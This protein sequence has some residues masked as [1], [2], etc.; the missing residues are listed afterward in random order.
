MPDVLPGMTETPLKTSGL[1]A[2]RYWMH[3]VL[4]VDR[5]VGFTVL[6]RAWASSAGLVTVA[7]IARF[8]SPAQQ[9]YY[10]T[11][12]SLVALQIV[13]ELGFSFVILQ[14]ASHE[15]SCLHISGDY[16]I[17]GDPI[18]HA[19]LASV[20]QKAVRWYSAGAVL[21]AVTLV[22]SGFYF[23]A[24]HQHGDTVSWHLA[25]YLD[26]VMAALNFQ[27]DP[28]L[29]FLEGCGYV[30]AVARLRFMQSV[31][32][33]LLAW[34]A[35]ATGHGLFAPSMMLFGMASCSLLWLY[36][37]R[38]LLLGLLRHDTGNNRIRWGE[39][40]WPFQWRIAVSWASG[41][42]LFS[43]F[44]PVLFA[45]RGA[46]EAG[47]MGM[48]LSLVNAI[49][50]IA[51]SWVSTKSA[52]FGAL[53]AGKKYHEL[54][55]IFS[56]AL[57]QSFAVAIAGALIAWLGCVYINLQHLRFAQRLLPPTSLGILMICMVVN[58]IIFAQAYY[59]RAH[60][61]EVFFLNSLIG[62]LAV[63]LSTFVVGRHY[64]AAGIVL[65]C[66]IVNFG[67]LIWA[68]YKFRK[69]RTLWHAA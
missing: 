23:F 22:P 30:A 60:K 26:A 17:T 4:G 67:G 37:K 39:E 1:A 6:A 57:R 3:R 36:R 38:R 7:L 53:I 46:I 28:L 55:R 16:E 42:F 27:L 51:V 54:D 66:C 50:A 14:L 31:A 49:Q 45:Y 58:I 35:L 64:G 43:L 10:Y 48:S 59:L 40:V 2:I 29:S 8:L 56:T 25:W 11:F 65:S 41:Y 32:G 21:V 12:G 18:A 24:T 69:Y 20:L 44:N 61:Q 5:A 13:F 34:G 52:P 63:A 68:T 9:G 15:R 19:R 62:A 47:Q 33:S